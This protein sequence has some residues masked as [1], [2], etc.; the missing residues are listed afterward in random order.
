VTGK[1][2]HER[3]QE[4]ALNTGYLADVRASVF[5]LSSALTL[6]LTDFAHPSPENGL[7]I[8]MGN[9]L[10]IGK[11]GAG[12]AGT[13]QGAWSAPNALLSQQAEGL[14]THRFAWEFTPTQATGTLRS[15]FLYYD[16]SS[17]HVPSLKRPP[18][19]W[20]G[21]PQW[22]VGSK[23]I[24]VAP[25][26][27]TQ[28]YVVDYYAKTATLHEKPNTLTMTGIARE[29]ATGHAFI[30]DYAAKKLC[31]FADEDTDFTAENALAEYPCTAAYVGKGLVAG[32]LLYYMSGSTDPLS[33]AA[34]SPSG[35]AINLFKFA[36]KDDTAPELA[37]TITAAGLGVSTIQG[38]SNAAFIDDYLI[39]LP[40]SSQSYKC[41]AM[42][43][44]G[45]EVKLGFSGYYPST[46]TT[47]GIRPTPDR[48]ILLSGKGSDESLSSV[49]PMA[50][51][52]LLLDEPIVKDAQHSLSVSY[53]L[54][55]QE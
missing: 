1:V 37:E 10:G 25:K 17:S 24:D 29:P 6:L 9:P 3:T 28:Y 12:S 51:S 32:D 45:E 38:S 8:P 53:T 52:H 5:G 15:L 46:S 47:L 33:S 34:G 20:K 23:A 14:T 39:S 44:V 43:V 13:Y 11:Y 41:P 30:Y 26:T 55:L 19:T 35:A 48:Q 16:N 36:Y 4:N 50:I 42:R 54:T 21:T 18:V 49:I 22:S 7:I 40:Q 31:E 27:A 2:T